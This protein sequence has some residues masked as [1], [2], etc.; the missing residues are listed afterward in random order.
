[1]E[2]Q[3][4][5]TVLL[6]ISLLT[7]F[8]ALMMWR[9][10][11]TLYRDIWSEPKLVFLLTSLILMGG[12]TAKLFQIYNWPEYLVPLSFTA[13]L[14]TILINREAAVMVALLTSLICLTVFDYDANVF[15]IT[16]AGSMAG[17]LGAARMR[18]RSEIVLAGLLVMA[19]NAAVILGLRLATNFSGDWIEQVG[20]GVLSGFLSAALVSFLVWPLERMFNITTDIRLIELSDT[21]HPLLLK[22]MTEAPGTFQHTLQVASFADVAARAINANSLL[23][24]VGAYYHDIGK[25]I[26][27]NYFSENQDS[28]NPHDALSPAMSCKI[29]VDHVKEGLRLAREHKLPKPIVDMIPQHHGTCEVSFLLL[30]ARQ[31]EKYDSVSEDDF[32]YPGPRPQSREAAILMLSDACEAVSRTLENPTHG[33]VRSTVEKLINDRFIDSQFDEC[34]LTLKDLHGIADSLTRSIMNATH[35]RIVYPVSS[36]QAE[37]KEKT[38]TKQQEA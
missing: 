1:M 11:A 6:G 17:I 18:R 23:A 20:Y 34:D 32:R 19:A 27:P 28:K 36:S 31:S 35:K 10:L 16:L 8:L 22:M 24:R 25:T 37:E 38:S 33:R 4:R 21:N 12:V 2:R 9:Y 5:P 13:I 29:I 3:R 15:M 26:R 7:I 14:A 30:K